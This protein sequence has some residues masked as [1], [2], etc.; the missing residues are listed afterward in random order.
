MTIGNPSYFNNYK[1]TDESILR[2]QIIDTAGQEQYRAIN[3]TYYKNADCC[4]LVYDITDRKDFDEI[5]NYFFVKIKELCKKNVKVILVGNKTDLEA[6]RKISY[7]EAAHL[8]I[9]NNYL[10]I[11]TSC[12]LNKNVSKVFEKIFG[13]YRLFDKYSE[14]IINQKLVFNRNISFILDLK[15]KKYLYLLSLNPKFEIYRNC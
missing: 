6:E 7:N 14:E 12:L 3:E 11:E 15:N 13:I 1:L 8:A 5:K 4:I 10:F 2:C 9:L